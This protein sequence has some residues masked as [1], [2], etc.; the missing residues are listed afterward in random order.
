MTLDQLG[1]LHDKYDPDRIVCNDPVAQW[2]ADMLVTFILGFL[3][4][5][6]FGVALMVWAW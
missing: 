4:G 5:G 1:M 3:S 6:L 2:K